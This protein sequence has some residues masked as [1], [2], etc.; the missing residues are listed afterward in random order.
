MRDI[1][2]TG[3]YCISVPDDVAEDYDGQVASFWK[4]GANLLLQVSSY[5]R[6]EGAQVGAQERLRRRLERESLHDISHSPPVSPNCPDWAAASGIDEEGVEW[7]FIYAVWDDLT[8]LL[9]VSRSSGDLRS[10]DCWTTE[11]VNSLRRTGSTGVS[12]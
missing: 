4:E 5:A 6:Y 10:V 8:I 2:P 12:R 7:I 1:C 3:S 9:T 11:A